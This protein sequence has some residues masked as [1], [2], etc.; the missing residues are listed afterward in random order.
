MTIADAWPHRRACNDECK[1][2]CIRQLCVCVRNTDKTTRT[3]MIST[4][5]RRWGV[6]DED[7]DEARSSFVVMHVVAG[8]SSSLRRGVEGETTTNNTGAGATSK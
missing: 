4:G 8:A 1:S 3:M 7:E 2:G 5:T 6:A